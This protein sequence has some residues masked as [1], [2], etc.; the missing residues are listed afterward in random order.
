MRVKNEYILDD[1][2]PVSLANTVALKPV[3]LG[4]IAIASVQLEFT[5]TP[6]GNFRLQVSNDVGQITAAGAAQQETGVETWT[7]YTSPVTVSAAGNL[8]IEAKD[9]GAEWMRVLYTATG[10]GTSPVLVKARAKVKGF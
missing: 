1:S 3:W 5:G 8:Y 2:G 6:A 7:D 10:P 9:I 4:H